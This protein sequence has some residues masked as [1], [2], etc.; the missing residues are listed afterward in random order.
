VL[1]AQLSSNKVSTHLSVIPAPTTSFF[2]NNWIPELSIH[3][4]YSG[5]IK[6]LSLIWN[7]RHGE[8]DD[9]DTYPIVHLHL[10]SFV[11]LHI[12]CLWF[13]LDTNLELCDILLL[14]LGLHYRIRNTQV[15]NQKSESLLSLFLP[16]KLKKK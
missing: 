5:F 13:E 11:C 3:E 15:I 2:F 14:L 1:L 4:V 12:T 7:R 10:V 8:G 9:D 16:W 6:L